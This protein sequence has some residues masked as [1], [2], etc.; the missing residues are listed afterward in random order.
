M[1]INFGI[2]FEKKLF[3]SRHCGNKSLFYFIDCFSKLIKCSAC[4]LPAQDCILKFIHTFYF[5]T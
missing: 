2:N 4:E 5:T 1:L 3:M